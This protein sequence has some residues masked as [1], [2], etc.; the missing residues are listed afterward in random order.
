ME[1]P[2]PTRRGRKTPPRRAR[3]RNR[4]TRPRVRHPGKLPRQRRLTPSR[5][6]TPLPKKALPPQPRPWRR[7]QTRVSSVPKDVPYL[8]RV[9]HLDATGPLEDPK[10][11]ERGPSFLTPRRQIRAHPANAPRTSSSPRGHPRRGAPRESLP[12]TWS[13]SRAEALLPAP[14]PG[15]RAAVRRGSAR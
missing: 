2:V 6:R 12:R 14:P 9:P 8:F 15:S 11:S 5:R 13:S 10:G 1:S 7:L 4:R 3:T